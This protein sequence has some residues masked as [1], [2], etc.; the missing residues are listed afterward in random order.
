MLPEWLWQNNLCLINHQIL[1]SN[2]QVNIYLML[3]CTCLL[4]DT[5]H[6]LSLILTPTSLN[7]ERGH[8]LV[9]C[10]CVSLDF[11]LKKPHRKSNSIVQFVLDIHATYNSLKVSLLWKNT[12][13]ALHIYESD[14]LLHEGGKYWRMNSIT[15]RRHV[16]DCI[17]LTVALIWI[18]RPRGSNPSQGKLETQWFISVLQRPLMMTVP[19]NC[20]DVE[21]CECVSSNE[22]TF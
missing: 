10:L 7:L 8:L 18:P 5:V 12:P 2:L 1:F 4:S 15:N 21:A 11:H 16:P 6:F 20:E 22:M 13:R 3:F 19:G 17:H 14:S 9:S